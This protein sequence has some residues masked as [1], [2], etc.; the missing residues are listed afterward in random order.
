MFDVK[1]TGLCCILGLEGK[2]KNRENDDHMPDRGFYWKQLRRQN[3]LVGSSAH[4]RRTSQKPPGLSSGLHL[5]DP[6]EFLLKARREKAVAPHS[7]T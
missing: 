6:N 4:G 5:N 3:A 2:R 7:K 1:A